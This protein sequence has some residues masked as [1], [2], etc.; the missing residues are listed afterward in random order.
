MSVVYCKDGDMLDRL[1]KSAYNTE[2]PAVELLLDSHY[3]DAGYSLADMGAVYNAGD[4]VHMKELSRAQLEPETP[5]K[6]NIFEEAYLAT[7]KPGAWPIG[8]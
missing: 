7:Q 1:C 4:L 5:R 8:S 6:L 2:H 3:A